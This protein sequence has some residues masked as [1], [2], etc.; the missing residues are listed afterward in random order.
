[1]HIA[2]LKQEDFSVGI[3]EL[4]AKIGGRRRWLVD[5]RGGKGTPERK[6]YEYKVRSSDL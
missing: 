5:A 6:L 2:S 3:G 1:V 4:G